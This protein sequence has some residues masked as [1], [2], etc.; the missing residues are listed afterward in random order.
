[1]GD[2]MR[3]PTALLHRRNRGTG[4]AL[5]A[6]RGEPTEPGPPS[7]VLR[8]RPED[9]GAAWATYARRCRALLPRN[10]AWAAP[11]L[12]PQQPRP[13]LCAHTQARALLLWHHHLPSWAQVSLGCRHTRTPR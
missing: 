13:V 4:P 1:M 10:L 7:H 5:V 9:L 2:A 6:V 12:D 8:P 11:L 3:S